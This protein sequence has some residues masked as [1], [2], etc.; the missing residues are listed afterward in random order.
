[1]SKAFK[2][3]K[4]VK[5]WSILLCVSILPVLSPAVADRLISFEAS[6][7]AAFIGLIM[8]IISIA[9]IVVYKNRKKLLASLF[10]KQSILDIWECSDSY[11]ENKGLQIQAYFSVKGVFYAGRPYPLKSYE[12]VITGTELID[13]E[14]IALSVV[15][16]VPSSRSGARRHKNVINIPVSE[17][18]EESAKK[19]AGYYARA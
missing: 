11:D 5:F 18:K 8:V 2:S 7:A 10:D 13:D 1:M 12:C 15:Y 17:G 3:R 6:M 4:M 14:G 19:I 9:M 16:T